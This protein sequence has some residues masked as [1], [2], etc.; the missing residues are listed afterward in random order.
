MEKIKH[1][2][3]GGADLNKGDY[4]GRLDRIVSMSDG[5]CTKS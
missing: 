3:E 1:L 4:D 2:I 5:C